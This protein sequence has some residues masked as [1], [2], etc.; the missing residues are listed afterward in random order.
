MK[1]LLTLGLALAMVLSLAP[2]AFA[3]EFDDTEGY[4]GEEA[5][6]RWAEYGVVEGVGGGNFNPKGTLT[7]AQA[8]EIISNLMHL[9]EKGDISAY[10]DVPADAWYA[11]PIAKCVAAGIL[12]GTSDTTMSPSKTCDRETMFVMVARAVGIKPE[13]TCEK[14]FTDFT[15]VHSWA[16]GY[17]NALVNIGAVDGKEG[18]ILDPVANVSRGQS[19]V[20]LDKLIGLYVV[21]E[22]E[23]TLPEEGI[24]L[25]L[26]DNVQLKGTATEYPIVLAGEASKVDMSGVTG[27]ATVIVKTDD[28][29]VTGAPVGTEIITEDAEN[30]TVNGTEVKP[31]DDIFVTA[32]STPST[33]G[34][35][36]TVTPTPPSP[37]EK[38]GDDDEEEKTPVD[39]KERPN[40]EAGGVIWTWDADE[41]E[42]VSGDQ[43]ET[44][45]QVMDWLKDQAEKAEG[46]EE[47]FVVT[48]DGKE[49]SW[50]TDEQEWL[51]DDGEELSPAE[52]E[53][54]FGGSSESEPLE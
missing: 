42:Y 43:R 48:V 31:E 12:N 19:M 26:A 6:D 24:V 15:S 30:V 1:K 35:G 36:G 29:T 38:P 2:A 22:G 9:T 3:A 39:K 23:V 20:F 13:T 18:N 8:A 46:E 45:E 28:V 40:V 53:D 54:L 11:E 44:Y 32:P 25:V 17:I 4:Y 41:Q 27:T 21:E 51:T 16:K 34:T 33:S 49:Y 37:E 14:T 5:I 52:F 50:D 7:R 47:E 10:T